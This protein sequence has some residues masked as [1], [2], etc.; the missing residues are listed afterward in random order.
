MKKPASEIAGGCEIWLAREMGREVAGKEAV[1]VVSSLM[2]F[3]SFAILVYKIVVAESG[4]HTVGHPGAG[5][6]QSH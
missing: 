4:S 3:T 5:P 1:Q 2:P 6:F